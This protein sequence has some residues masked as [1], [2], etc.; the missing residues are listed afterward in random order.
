MRCNQSKYLLLRLYEQSNMR[1]VLQLTNV[2]NLTTLETLD[3][4]R[5]TYP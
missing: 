3:Y 2:S 5:N 4:S 1:K